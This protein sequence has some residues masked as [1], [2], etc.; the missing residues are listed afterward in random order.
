MIPILFEAD[1]TSFQSNGIGRLVDCLRQDTTEERNGIFEVEFDYPVTGRHFEDIIE[2]RIIYCLHDDTKIPQPFDIYARSAPIDGVVTFYAHH[3]SYRLQYSILQPF[4]AGSCAAVMGM[5]AEKS[6]TACP[7]SFWTDKQ[8]SGTFN[9]AAP[10]SIK[11][12]LGGVEGSVLD[13]YGK[14][15]YE[16]DKWTVKFHLNRGRDTGVQIRYGK[17]LLNLT[18][19]IDTSGFYSAVIPYWQSGDGDT[20]VRLDSWIVLSS[21]AQD[22]LVPVKAVPMDLSDQWE[23]AP[24]QAQLAEKALQRMEDAEPWIPDHTLKVDFVALWQTDEYAN[25]APLERVGLCDKVDVIYPALGVTA[26][27]RQIIKVVYDGLNERY[28]EME[29]GTAKTSFAEVVQAAT[30]EA[31]KKEVPSKSYLQAAVDHATDMITGGDGGN[32]VIIRDAN[33][34]PIGWAQMDTDDITT[35]VNVWRMNSGG[36]GHSHNGWNGPFDLAMT[37]DGQF[38]ADR[39]TAGTLNANI[40]NAGVIQHKVWNEQTQ[41]FDL[42]DCYFDLEADELSCSKLKSNGFNIKFGYIYDPAYSTNRGGVSFS[43]DW[44]ESNPLVIIPPASSGAAGSIRC[45]HFAILADKDGIVRIGAMVKSTYSGGRERV[46]FQGIEMELKANRTTIVNVWDRLGIVDIYGIGELGP[47]GYGK[48]KIYGDV[49]V[50]G[51]LAVNGR[52]V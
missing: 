36:F 31:I 38:V 12:I 7:F 16:W 34:K 18:Q 25:I 47:S 49:D 29:I 41:Q 4:T 35:A 20:L 26:R 19:D 17:N 46:E 42:G 39:I 48:I 8:V 33:G 9:V 45:K 50:R 14:G 3:V 21:A 10:V 37:A 22:G 52:A 13:I 44:Q 11:E 28:K 32:Y 51:S 30:E 5:L 27:S 6:I 1:E 43:A 24:T 2:G 15:E 23:E 40:I